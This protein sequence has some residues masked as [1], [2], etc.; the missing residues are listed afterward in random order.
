[1]CRG[2]IFYLPNA[3]DF[4]PISI[5]GLSGWGWGSGCIGH[6]MWPSGVFVYKCSHQIIW[7][8]R[9]P[10]TMDDLLRTPQYNRS[11]RVCCWIRSS[12]CPVWYFH[13]ILT[14]NWRNGML[15]AFLNG[16]ILWIEVLYERFD[17][18]NSSHSKFSLMG[19][20]ST[21][22]ALKLPPLLRSVPVSMEAS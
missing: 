11:R 8:A 22:L 18:L 10:E 1:M 21:P 20:D 12:R 16:L 3:S 4:S 2:S 7:W 14:G 6:S 5:C 15:V 19:G 9:R 17:W 13:Y